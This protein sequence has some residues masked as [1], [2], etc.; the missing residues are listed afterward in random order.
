MEP[1][2]RE[3]RDFAKAA[4]KALILENGKAVLHGGLGINLKLDY[5]LG[6]TDHELDRMEADLEKNADKYAAEMLD[7]MEAKGLRSPED[8]LARANEVKQVADAYVD[9]LVKSV[10]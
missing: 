6:I 4:F 10:K 8:M 5:Q 7:E 2:S 1:E 3:F 9:R